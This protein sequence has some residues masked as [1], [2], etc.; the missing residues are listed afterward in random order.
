MSRQVDDIYYNGPPVTI[1]CLPAVVG[2]GEV[3]H[4]IALWINI[5]DYMVIYIV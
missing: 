5:W 2:D 1:T 4:H 3:L